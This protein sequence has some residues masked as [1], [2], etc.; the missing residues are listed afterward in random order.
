MLKPTDSKKTDFYF[1]PI[2][3]KRPD[4]V[5]RMLLN[6]YL[7]NLFIK[8]SSNPSSDD[9]TSILDGLPKVVT[10]IQERI[11][12]AQ[13]DEKSTLRAEMKFHEA[14]LQ[15]R[16]DISSTQDVQAQFLRV[17]KFRGVIESAKESPITSRA[18]NEYVKQTER[19]LNS[20]PMICAIPVLKAAQE[21]AEQGRLAKEKAAQEKAARAER[22][23]IGEAERNF[24]EVKPG[25][26]TPEKLG[27]KAIELTEGSSFASR[28]SSTETADGSSGV[29]ERSSTETVDVDKTPVA[30]PE[31]VE[32][33]DEDLVVNPANAEPRVTISEIPVKKTSW[34][35]GVFGYR[36]SQ[37][38]EED[39]MGNIAHKAI[40]NLQL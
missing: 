14:C 28:A 4:G 9:A 1:W 10:A 35:A 16:L 5:N 23:K 15:F 18:L 30:K 2:P 7:H 17:Q 11:N 29:L 13:L 12:K 40:G 27:G 22:K 39:V 25:R 19:Y 24:R 32:T 20:D 34:L 31:P 6:Q 8:S 36:A 21:R 37:K 3:E 38:P 26:D 33:G